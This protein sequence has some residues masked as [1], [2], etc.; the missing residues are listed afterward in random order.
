MIFRISTEAE[1]GSKT[2]TTSQGGETAP[3]NLYCISP[4]FLYSYFNLALQPHTISVWLIY[5]FFTYLF[6]FCQMTPPT[7]YFWILLICIWTRKNVHAVKAATTTST[8]SSLRRKQDR[9]FTLYSSQQIRD[10][11]VQWAEQYPT[12]MKLTKKH[13]V[14]LLPELLRSA[15]VSIIYSHCKTLSHTPKDP[16]NPIICQK[17]CYLVKC[18]ETNVSVQMPSWRLQPCSFWQRLVSHIQDWN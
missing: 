13:M 6:R 16:S 3:T 7:V 10:L 17:S 9:Q 1:Y 8:S 4:L 5:S 14:Y 15:V 12:L 2:P 18:M 11:L